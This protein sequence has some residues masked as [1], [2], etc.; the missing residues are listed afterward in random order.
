MQR[1]KWHVIINETF[2]TAQ[3]IIKQSVRVQFVKQCICELNV[4]LL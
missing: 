1:A 2:Q 3:N 4:Q